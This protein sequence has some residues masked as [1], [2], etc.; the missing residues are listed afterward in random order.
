MPKR[1]NFQLSEE[2]AKQVEQA[3][4]KDKRA[5]VRQRAS[6]FS[7]LLFILTSN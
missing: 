7:I 2:H 3:K 4:R 1:L 6:G 5:E